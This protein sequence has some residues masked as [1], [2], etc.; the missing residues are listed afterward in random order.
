MQPDMQLELT[1]ALPAS[2][3]YLPV[4]LGTGHE[5]Q[6]STSWFFDPPSAPL[7]IARS[8]DQNVGAQ[9]YIEA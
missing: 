1:D 5:S 2:A 8:P 6:A 9:N 3:S 7:I 4:C